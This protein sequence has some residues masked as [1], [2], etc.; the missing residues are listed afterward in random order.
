MTGSQTIPAATVLLLRQGSN[1]DPQVFMVK[2]H[3]QIDFA[4]GALVFPGGKVDEVDRDAALTARCRGLAGAS[5]H[6]AAMR[7]AAIREAY[8]ECGVLL[9][10]REGEVDVIDGGTLRALSPWRDRLNAGTATLREMVEA[11]GLELACDQLVLFAHWI[12]PNMMPR[13]FDTYFYLAAAPESQLAVHDGSESVDSLWINPNRALRECEQGMWKIIFPTRMN[14][15]KLGRSRRVEDA[16]I[17]ARDTGIVTVEPWLEEREGGH[18]L[19]I[20]AEAGYC[21]TEEALEN[22][23]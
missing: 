2:R 11:E 3:H 22:V 18:V 21:L 13:R 20:P 10:R 5:A 6:D 8:E 9:A 1:G 15:E 19:C 23:N 7:I 12:T 14:L 4:S 16:I 17:A